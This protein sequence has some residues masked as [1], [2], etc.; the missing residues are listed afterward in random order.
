MPDLCVEFVYVWVHGGRGAE[1]V[2]FDDESF[3]DFSE[4]GYHVRDVAL[5]DVVFYEGVQD[6]AELGLTRA[7]G[8][9]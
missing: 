7:A 6:F 8:G 4:V 9:T 5:G 1:S 3:G 2:S